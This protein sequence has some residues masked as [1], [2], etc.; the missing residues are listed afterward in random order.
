M[1]MKHIFTRAAF[2]A[3][4]ASGAFASAARLG[5][6]GLSAKGATA[7][8]S[9]WNLIADPLEYGAPAGTMFGSTSVIYPRL[10]AGLAEVDAEPGFELTS[11]NLVLESP[12]THTDFT[13]ST[14]VLA[15]GTTQFIP[16]AMDLTDPNDSPPDT[17]IE[18]GYLQ[19]FWQATG[20][21]TVSD[22]PGHVDDFDVLFN[23]LTSDPNEQATFTVYADPSTDDGGKFGTAD[24]YFDG[25]TTYDAND[26]N[27]D[28]AQT[29]DNVVV[30]LPVGVPEPASF[31][32]LGC[33]SAGL[34]LHRRRRDSA[35]V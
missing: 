15:Q 14:G 35:T 34:L 8:Q 29:G 24:S 7:A 21:A 18:P 27:V 28:D 1:K 9:Q 10:V 6:A 33:C 32:L 22:E 16:T 30:N 13:Y 31:T 25:T 20:G 19:V 11:I 26:I 23:N 5:K 3:V 17:A 12:I 2:V 4:V